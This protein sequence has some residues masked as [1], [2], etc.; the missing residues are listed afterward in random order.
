MASALSLNPYMTGKYSFCGFE[1]VRTE[2][3]N[4]GLLNVLLVDLNTSLALKHSQG[5]MNVG[6]VFKFI[7]R[8]C[9][10]YFFTC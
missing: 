7:Q 2:Q 4:N 8:H 10:K 1:I 6:Y 9:N 5:M 3:T